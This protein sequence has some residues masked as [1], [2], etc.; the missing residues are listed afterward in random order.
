M[1]KPNN[2]NGWVV[3][4]NRL[5][6]CILIKASGNRKTGCMSQTYIIRKD[7]TP[8]NAVKNG[9][10]YAICGDCVH[11][12]HGQ[13]RGKRTCYVNLGQG[14]TQVYKSFVD[15][16]YSQ[17]NP[18]NLSPRLLKTLKSRMLRIG[19][20]GDPAMVP[21][22][23]WNHLLSFFQGHTGYTHQWKKAQ[24]DH[25]KSFLMAS[26]DT[27]GETQ[28]SKAMGWR[29]FLVV[30]HSET[31]FKIQEANAIL[32]PS[33]SHRRQCQDCG[34]CNGNPKD[35]GKNIFIPAHGPSKRF[36]LSLV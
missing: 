19:T 23:V 24:N 1:A 16:K 33:V 17:W 2:V 14:P 29:S 26:C 30:D 20:Y 9:K 15:G 3:W 28:A 36:V 13:K 25:L 6:V 22:R 5:V 31:R 34:L 10:D 11:R 4:Q 35:N 27:L 8:V 7:D 18:K 21:T 12:L 32:C